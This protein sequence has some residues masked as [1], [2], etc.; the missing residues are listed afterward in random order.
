ML[1][2]WDLKDL[3]EMRAAF[4]IKI[5]NGWTVRPAQENAEG[6][7]GG[8]H[9]GTGSRQRREDHNSKGAVR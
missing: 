1:Y 4:F 2:L 7:Q 6:Q 5:N 3:A 9:P 8:A